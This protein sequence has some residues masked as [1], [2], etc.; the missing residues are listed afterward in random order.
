MSVQPINLEGFAFE[1]DQ[2]SPLLASKALGPA[3]FWR[4][5]AVGSPG[6][7]ETISIPWLVSSEM[8]F[9]SGLALENRTNALKLLSATSSKDWPL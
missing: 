6:A 4:I 9:T 5:R 7:M 2:R 3:A 1:S 8:V